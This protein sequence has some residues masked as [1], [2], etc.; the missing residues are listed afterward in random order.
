MKLLN[1]L[2]SLISGTAKKENLEDMTQG[3]ALR[4]LTALF[5]VLLVFLALVSAI[6]ASII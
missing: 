5:G 4:V 2:F 1:D 6:V 3:S